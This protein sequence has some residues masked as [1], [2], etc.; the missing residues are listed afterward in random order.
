METFKKIAPYI[1]I[2]VLIFIVFR[3][4]NS[5]NDKASSLESTQGFLNDTISYYTNKLGQ[6]VAE[7][8]AITGDKQAL[9]I[10]LSKQVDS[11]RQLKRLVKKYRSISAAG[12]ITQETRIDTV[13]IPYEI[14]VPYEFNR[15][16]NKK[17]D[18]YSIA[19]TSD[20]NGVTIENLTVPNT[21]SFAIGNKKKGWFKSEYRIEAV[22]SNPYVQTTGLDAYTLDVPNKR[23]GLSLYVGYGASSNFKLEPSAG[24]AL[25]YTLFKF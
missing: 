4:C 8:K 25:T 17:T 19:G 16:W 2:I 6:E 7:K 12:N 13:E 14:K 15:K 1:A 22:N 11:T 23:L 9:E 20:Q 21:L 3:Q 18:D 10:L 24:I 5:A